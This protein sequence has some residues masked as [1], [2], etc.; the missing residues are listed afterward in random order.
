M[1]FLVLRL[2]CRYLVIYLQEIE[3]RRYLQNVIIEN[4][5]VCGS[6]CCFENDVSFFSPAKI[7]LFK[8]S[9]INSI[10]RCDIC[11]K[12]IIINTPERRQLRRSG[13]FI[14]NFEHISNLFQL[15]QLLAPFLLTH[16][17]PMFH[18]YI[19]LIKK[20][21]WKHQKTGGFLMFSGGIDVEHWLKM[22]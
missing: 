8:V 20:S 4:I 15:F 17:Q 14:V 12:L 22:G 10:K 2:W 19:P 7:F 13:V 1:L 3:N 5:Y 6:I 18:F 21:P 9:N 16:F 11:S